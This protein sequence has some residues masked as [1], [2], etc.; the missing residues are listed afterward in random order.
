M[1]KKP[2]A[3]TL[4]LEPLFLEPPLLEALFLEPV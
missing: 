2:N 4:V 3:N 1:E